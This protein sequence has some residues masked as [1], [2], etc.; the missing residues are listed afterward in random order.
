MPRKGGPCALVTL[1]DARSDSAPAFS[2]PASAPS[3]AEGLCRRRSPC[4]CWNSPARAGSCCRCQ[5]GP[6]AKSSPCSA[7]YARRQWSRPMRWRAVFSANP[8]PLPATISVCF[9]AVQGFWSA[10]TI[11]LMRRL[12]TPPAQWHLPLHRAASALRLAQLAHFQAA[13]GDSGAPRP[14]AARL[15]RLRR[16]GRLPPRQPLADPAFPH[17]S[18]DSIAGHLALGLHCCVSATLPPL[19]PP[20]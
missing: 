18:E 10:Q 16:T 1:P 12:L 8:L 13:P 2:D 9:D 15:P 11:T 4:C 7:G 5:P 3:L 20:S 6:P 14:S 17:L 19:W